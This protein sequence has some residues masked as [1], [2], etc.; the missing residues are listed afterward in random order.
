MR[1]ARNSLWAW[2]T[3]M[4]LLIL[5]SS[6]IFCS[7]APQDQ[8]IKK[9][10]VRTPTAEI[11]N[12]VLIKPGDS[13]DEIISKAANVVPSLRQVAWQERELTAFVHFGMNTFTDREWGEGT[14]D[15]ILFNPVQFDASQWARVMRDAGMRMIIVTAKHHDGFCLWPSKYTDHSVKSSSWQDGNGDVVGDV[16]K[17]CKEHG[18][19]FGIYLSPWDRHEPSYGDSP[20]YNE[21]FRNQLRELL[22]GYGEVSEVW[23]DGACGEGPNGKRQVYDWPSYY[24]VIRELQPNAVIFGMGPDIRWVGTESG[25]GRETE[26]SIVPNIVQNLDSIAASSQ[27][28][29]VDGAFIPG[30]LTGSDL[31]SREKIMNAKSLVWY[32]AETDVSIRPGWFYHPQQDDQVK[33]PEKLVDIYYSSVGRNGVL[34]LNVPPDKRGLIHGNDIK[35][36][37]GMKKILAQTFKNNLL[38]GSRVIASNEKKGNSA[39]FLLDNNK[40]TYWTTVDTVTT[41]MVEFELPKEQSFDRAMLQEQIQVGQRVEKFRL[42][43]FG[44]DGWI[45][46]ARGTTIGYKRLLRFPLIT[47][48]KV[49]LVIEE[50]RTNPTLSSFGLFKAPPDL[51]ISPER[52]TYVD[53]IHVTL[54]SNEEAAIYYTLDGSEPN[55]KSQRYSRPII[56]RESAI[57]NAIAVTKEGN[58][59]LLKTA[60]YIRAKYGITIKNSF[61]SRYTAGGV[62]GII[63]GL[64]GSTD[65]S[66][67]RWQGYE[68][69]DLDVVLD[70]GV[71][72]VIKKISISFLQDI[73]NSIFL[74]KT[75]EFYGSH[76]GVDFRKFDAAKNNIPETI[77]GAFQKRF[78]LTPSRTSGRYIKVVAKNIGVCPSW[79]KGA[80]SK[81]WLFV[82]EIDVV[83]SDR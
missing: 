32:P 9:Q 11:R 27:Q 75:V 41:A 49:R 21:Y 13:S 52:A 64:S 53:T 58:S 35:N 50:S 81:A 71:S 28:D 57:L 29:P 46:F 62:M 73:A 61:S 44:E 19:K 63:D 74:P 16:A 76:G 10:E 77:Q 1:C 47:T 56:L 42:E 80:G 37:L 8:V 78:D 3:G 69:V 54:S 67:G 22:T 59:S 24:K 18:L 40:R 83:T 4:M 6:Q 45:E 14:E 82:D 34:L 23:F 30:D 39:S 65:F 12:Y 38:T 51:T 17:A 5:W 60:S 72:T 26:W 7:P 33:T 31:G 36:L 20:R 79:H 48:H 15:P 68:G 66:D 70:F 2:S 55:V 43:A 25:Y